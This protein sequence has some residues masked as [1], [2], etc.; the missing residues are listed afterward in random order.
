MILSNV[1]FLKMLAMTVVLLG[2]FSF[3]SQV[4]AQESDNVEKQIEIENQL[5]EILKTMRESGAETSD[6]DEMDAGSEVDSSSEYPK[7]PSGSGGVEAEDET[8]AINR[9]EQLEARIAELSQQDDLSKQD[10]QSLK[11]LKLELR[12]AKS[13]ASQIKRTKLVRQNREDE[14]GPEDSFVVAKVHVDQGSAEAEVTFGAIAGELAGI[15]DLVDFLKATPVGAYRDYQL[16]SRHVDPIDSQAALE[17]VRNEYD[18]A[19]ER[20]RLMLEY[21]AARNAAM[22]RVKRSRRC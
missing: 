12:V 19:K 13:V 7:Y 15:V 4:Q 14:K 11:Q 21:I 22:Q 1:S 18:A 17:V 16:I 9:I 3:D 2:L 10:G 20:E 6:L 5:A 8:N